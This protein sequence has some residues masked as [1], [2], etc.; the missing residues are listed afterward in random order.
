M[1]RKWLRRNV[2][3]VVANGVEPADRTV[4]ILSAHP[5]MVVFP[6]VSL[7]GT[8][9]VGIGFFL[10]YRVV[11]EQIWYG[12]VSLGVGPWAAV[13]PTA[14]AL[15]WLFFAAFSA[16]VIFSNAGLVYCTTQVI[17]GERPSVGE[18]FRAAFGVLPH[19]F[20]YAVATATGGIV[21][22]ILERRTAWADS[23]VATTLGMSYVVATF[24]VVPAA[25]VDDATPLTMF[26]RS[27]ETVVAHLGERATVYLGVTL[28]V[29]NVFMV[30]LLLA[31]V[32]V[33][34][35][36]AFGIVDYAVVLE[37]GVDVLG[38]SVRRAELLGV[39][40][41]SALVVF[42]MWVGWVGGSALS[43]VAKTSL[44]VAIHEEQQSLPLFDIDRD[45][46][47]VV[48]TSDT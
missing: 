14:Y 42:P 24:F 2:F 8:L 18:G 43:A 7:V 12:L 48:P 28:V 33:T 11:G 30:P 20:T 41:L 27:A 35:N 36:G 4:R 23:V 1:S 3:T 29:A 21:V 34:V 15:V 44:Y 46:A 17:E 13:G 19:V 6:A 32:L 25:V 16:L 39:G 45:E 31:V 38:V 47:L 5:T 26:R 9:L 37:W 22:A 40:A 10:W